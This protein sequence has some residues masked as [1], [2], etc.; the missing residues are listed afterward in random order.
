MMESEKLEKMRLSLILFLALVFGIVLQHI[1]FSPENNNKAFAEKNTK[2]TEVN[3]VKNNIEETQLAKPKKASVVGFLNN[4]KKE[5]YKNTNDNFFQQATSTLKNSKPLPNKKEKNK[6]QDDVVFEEDAFY[7]S[8]SLF[9]PIKNYDVSEPEVLAKSAIVVSENG[10]VLF[11]KDADLKLP[12]ASLT[13]VMTALVVLENIDKNEIITITQDAIETEGIAGRFFPGE[14]MPAIDLLKIMLVISSNDAAGA[15]Y[16]YF[17]EKGV[18]LV[19]LMNKKAKEIGMENTN[20]SNPIGLDEPDNYSTARD[21]SKL[22]LHSLKNKDLWE[23]LS[24]KEEIIKAYSEGALN[25]KIMS[26]NKLMFDSDLKDIVIGGKT[27]YT[28]KAQG[29]L[30]SLFFADEKK[31]IKAVSVLLGADGIELRFSETKKLI[32]WSKKAY[33]F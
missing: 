4:E 17:K 29:C 28:Q 2:T 9:L 11:E 16:E 14:K 19:S 3:E 5:Q 32:E 21:Y 23:I 33:I 20:F 8:G 7:F 1:I 18:D 10:D 31:K 6:K 24:T 25:R 13:K 12:I 27:G 26:S 15:F 22:V 30:M